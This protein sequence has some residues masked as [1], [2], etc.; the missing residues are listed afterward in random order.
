M[1]SNEN[2]NSNVQPSVMAGWPFWRRFLLLF[3][4]SCIVIGSTAIGYW[5][6]AWE[7]EKKAIVA[8]H[9]VRLERARG[10]A[11]SRLELV[12]SDLL[13]LSK[14]DNLVR[15]LREGGSRT[16]WTYLAKDFVNLS[17]QKRIYDRIRFVDIDGRERIRVVFNDG[18]PSI[19]PTSILEERIDL[20]YV[21]EALGLE[22]EGV[23]VSPVDLALEGG[24]LEVPHKP[25][26]R[27]ASPA[28]DGA[29]YKRGLLVINYLASDILDHFRPLLSYSGSEGMLLNEDGFWLLANNHSLEWGGV[30]SGGDS[31]AR[32]NPYVWREILKGEDGFV[33]HDS[34]L[35]VFQTVRPL[36]RILSELERT[37]SRQASLEEK[38][39]MMGY[40]WKSV[41]HVP[42][43]EL[44]VRRQ[45][46]GRPIFLVSLILLFIVGIAC[47]VVARSSFMRRWHAH[48]VHEQKVW[49]ET[50]VGAMPDAVFLKDGMGSWLVVNRTGLA[51][52]GLEGREYRGMTEAELASRY[53]DKREALLACT[54]S[55]DLAWQKR[56]ISRGEE[57]IPTSDGD[58]RI[59]DVYKVPLFDESGNRQSLVVVGRDVTEQRLLLDEMHRLSRLNEPG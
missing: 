16:A 26:L 42:A 19:S 8:E 13:V 51:I 46:T 37:R 11:A 59:F 44:G 55:D 28:Y 36:L 25:I 57:I 24:V 53:P 48:V 34:G 30:R 5:N 22:S 38:R 20:P 15:Y 56:E 43:A 29:G 10:A 12:V 27:I 14:S 17:R 21:D 52:F 4:L 45:I 18:A 7:Q 35:W 31:F 58:A 40:H 23:L 32:A 3:S 1:Q 50:L 49:L 39:A 6:I 33:D 2:F 47:W 54:V 41:I 9:S